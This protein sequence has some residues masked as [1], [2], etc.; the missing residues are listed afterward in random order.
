[1]YRHSTSHRQNELSGS[2]AAG[3]AHE[4]QEVEGLGKAT[5]D[6]LDLLEEMKQAISGVKEMRQRVRNRKNGNIDMTRK[7]FATL[8]N[9]VND[10]EEQTIA[11][12]KKGADYTEKA[13][14]V[15][16]I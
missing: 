3:E 11:D 13:L 6:V 14:E 7:V 4:L 16:I 5:D 9:I 2:T 8:R 15:C 12:I 10:K 1:M